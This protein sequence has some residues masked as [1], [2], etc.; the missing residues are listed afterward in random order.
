MRNPGRVIS[1]QRLFD[2]VWEGEWTSAATRWRCTSHDCVRA[3]VTRMGLSSPLCA[4]WLP[5]RIDRA[6]N[7]DRETVSRVSMRAGTLVRNLRR[8]PIVTRLVL[9]VAAAMGVVLLFT[10]AFVYW[11]VEYALNRQLNQDLKA[12]NSV[13]DRAVADGTRPPTGTPGLKF[14]VYDRNGAV[15]MTSPDL[16][17]LATRSRVEEVLAGS[18]SD[19]DLGFFLP[20]PS[21][22]Y[23]VRPS[24]VPTPS[25]GSG[26]L[27][28]HQPQQARRGAA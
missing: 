3:W 25:W 10:T 5:H 2:V 22:A 9:A 7:Q 18:D 26:R 19:F 16:P 13:V 15:V 27:G 11:R 28:C 17:P 12:W 8:R 21:H 4:D 14:Q 23:R 6:R 24:V 1:R 20:A